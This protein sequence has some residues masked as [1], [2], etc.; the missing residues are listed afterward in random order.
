MPEQAMFVP[1]PITQRTLGD[2]AVF[3]YFPKQI[4]VVGVGGAGCNIINYLFSI[5]A[6]GSHMIAVDTDEKLLSVIRADEKFQLGKNLARGMGA[7]GDVEIGRLAAEK[8]GWKLDESFR[9]TKLMFI[10]AGMGGGTG[11]GALPVIAQQARDLGAVV[12]A[13]VTLPFLEDAEARIKA[14][15][16][17][18]KLLDVAN[19]TIVI[20]FEKLRGYDRNEPRA[21]AYGM[22]DELLAEKLKTIIEGMTQRPLVHVNILDLEQILKDGGLSIMLIGRDRSDDNLLNVINNTLNYPLSGID[23][24]GAK[25]AYIHVASGR[26]MSIEGVKLIV[27]YI[28][29]RI[30]STVNVLYGARLDNTTDCRVRITVI[31]TGLKKE[32]F[33]EAYS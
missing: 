17:I 30:N 22:M 24:H 8:T 21:E 23:Y 4:R 6:F 27:E 3:R 1:D 2:E 26:D 18:E 33:S 11:T 14:K 25:A 9:G 7:K 19:T 12:V 29:N 15:A 32:A 10:A 16:G 31:L 5:G 13:I 28:Y 20:D